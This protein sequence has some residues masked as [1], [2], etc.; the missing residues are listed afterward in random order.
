M[1]GSTMMTRVCRASVVASAMLAIAAFGAGTAH[2]DGPVQLK[3]RMGDYCLDAP[4]GSDWSPIVINPCNGTDFQRWTLTGDGELESVAFPGNCLAPAESGF[5]A[6]LRNCLAG[7]TH[8]WTIHP[9]GQV[10]TYIGACLNVLGG[11]SPGT[12]VSTQFCDGNIDQGW[13][14]VP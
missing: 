13:D 9:N 2:A 4:S 12:W 6:H 11:P 14:S 7:Y 8:H 3:S 1:S 5:T 10:T